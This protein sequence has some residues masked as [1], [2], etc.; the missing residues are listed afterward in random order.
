VE[1]LRAQFDAVMASVE[2]A[3]K[4]GAEAMFEHVYAKEPGRVRRQ[5]PGEEG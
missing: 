1:E 3:P 5:R 4:P 2:A